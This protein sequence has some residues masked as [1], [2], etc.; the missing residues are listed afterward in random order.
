MREATQ[1]RI[2]GKRIF[3]VAL[4][5]SLAGILW[6]LGLAVAAAILL[7]EGRPVLYRAERMRA[8]GRAFIIWK[9]RTMPPG[10][11]DGRATGGHKTRRLSPLGR[12]LRRTRLDEMP[13]L[14]NIL[15]GEMSFVGPRPPLRRHVEQF[16]DLYAEVLRAPPGLTGLA[17]LLY[18]RREEVLL[19]GCASADECE[20]LYTTLCIPA[21][22]RLDRA[23]LRR[24]GVVLDTIILLR[25]L[26]RL[27]WQLSPRRAR[28]G[29]PAR[30]QSAAL[31]LSSM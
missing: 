17:T 10:A 31:R 25:T 30:R 9:F 4:A 27:G 15:K 14:W 24:Q 5:L 2:R 16:P 13:Q 3:D 26:Q 8:P 18:H 6:P 19:A 7:A 29:I 11:D 12:W 21:K 20:R 1:R 22:A 28:R 23:Y